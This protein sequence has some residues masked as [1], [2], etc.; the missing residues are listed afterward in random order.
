MNVSER[1]VQSL[2][3][4][5]VRHLFGDPGDPSVGVLEAARRADRRG[6]VRR[7]VLTCGRFV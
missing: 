6:A 3:T 7:A 4:L 5:G 1:I 2:H